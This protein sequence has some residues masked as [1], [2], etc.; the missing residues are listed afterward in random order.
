MIRS[1]FTRDSGGKNRPQQKT[2][3][4]L[5]INAPRG[6][7]LLELTSDVAI[8]DCDLLLSAVKARLK[9]ILAECPNSTTAP[10]P[11]MTERIQANVLECAVALEQLRT[12]LMH[13]LD[14]REHLN[15]NVL[16]VQTALVQVN[17]E[18]VNILDRPV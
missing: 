18:L 2:D 15:L 5:A 10:P 11:A 17:T 7:T 16:D 4:T 9:L 6:T 13:E 12:T 3:F 1:A 14:R 8:E